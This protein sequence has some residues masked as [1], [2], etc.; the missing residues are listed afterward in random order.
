MTVNFTK[1]TCI[2]MRTELLRSRTILYAAVCLH[3]I[4]EILPFG[5]SRNFSTGQHTFTNHAK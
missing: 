5:L 3:F 2:W 1:R 4:D